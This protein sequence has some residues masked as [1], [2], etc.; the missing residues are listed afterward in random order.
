MTEQIALELRAICH[1]KSKFETAQII[2]VDKTKCLCKVTL[3]NSNLE[4]DEVKLRASDDNVTD[5]FLLFPAPKSIVLVNMDEH[6]IMM[7]TVIESIQY[8]QGDMLII[9]DKDKA[10]ITV[11]DLIINN[12]NNGGM[13]IIDKLKTEIDKLNSNFNTLKTA[14]QSGFNAVG[15]GAAANGATGASTFMSGAIL[16]SA[17]L[18]NI[19]NEHVK[20]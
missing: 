18:S 7:F 11:T 19:T 16:G 14:I 20:H 8:K 6:C 5:G 1:V 4:L 15:A 3:L 10:Q 12:G 17:D 2:S 9:I 13:I